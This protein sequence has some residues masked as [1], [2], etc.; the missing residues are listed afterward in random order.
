MK[1]GK[2]LTAFLLAAGMFVSA[3]GSVSVAA[4]DTQTEQTD[5]GYFVSSASYADADGFMHS[6]YEYPSVGGTYA[7][8]RKTLPSRYSSAEQGYVTSVKDQGST[9]TCWAH[10]A[11]AA[12]ESSLILHNGYT[13][14]LNLS[15][16]QLAYAAFHDPA[17]RLGLFDSKIHDNNSNGNSYLNAGNWN[18]NSL[19]CLAGWMGC[20][21]E[22]ANYSQYDS[23]KLF[24][25]Y[26]EK[27]SVYN[28]ES[29]YGLDTAHLQNC[30]RI[31]IAD[32]MDIKEHIMEYGAGDITFSANFYNAETFTYYCYDEQRNG[33][34]HIVALV[35]WD[36]A[37][38]K[39]NC[40]VDGYTPEQD[41]AW[42]I[43]NSWG[44]DEG[45]GGYMW[46]SY[47]DKSIQSFPVNFYSYEDADNYTYNYQYDD[48]P[49]ETLLMEEDG[50]ECITGGGYAA[51]VFTAQGDGETLEAVSFFSSNTNL[52]Y[53][54]DIYTGVAGSASPAAGTWVQTVSGTETYMGYHTVPLDTP[55]ALEKG[56]KFSVVV[57][58]YVK[59]N[60]NAEIAF[61]TDG[62]YNG[63]DE[64]VVQPGESFFSK[65][66]VSW[67]DI[68]MAVNCNFRIKAFTNAD[69]EPVFVQDYYTAYNGESREAVEEDL[70]K[71]V[72]AVE[73]ALYVPMYVYSNESYQEFQEWYWYASDILSN[74]E[75]Y[76]AVE[77]YHVRENLQS[78]YDALE[79]YCIEENIGP[80]YDDLTSIPLYDTISPWQDFLTVYNRA[81]EQSREEGV[82]EMQMWDLI[83]DVC[84]AKADYMREIVF[85]GFQSLLA[86][87]GDVNMDGKV[88]ILDATCLQLYLAGAE[89][90]D[91]YAV[92][93]A[94]VDDSY[95]TD[96]NDVTEIQLY[97]A[98]ENREFTKFLN[99]L[100]GAD[101]NALERESCLRQMR[102]TVREVE[103]SGYFPDMDISVEESYILLSVQYR[104][105]VNTLENS[106]K[107]SAVQICAKA[108]YLQNTLDNMEAKG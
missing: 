62:V 47:E 37:Y 90:L 91:M 94:D 81:V 43:K 18:F 72:S 49:N 8:S 24:A 95:K 74:T 86:D 56:E 17:D 70:D 85:H 96:I 5:S 73:N 19:A 58:L 20:T 41:G 53:T 3:W 102:R 104:D 61:H 78:A 99:Y 42:L 44:T 75:K 15:E 40:T 2:K 63:D 100:G 23:S 14:D 80:Y 36:D 83:Q 67:T 12:S 64:K 66:A 22:S 38:P 30:D 1:T 55:V 50:T 45:D 76:L 79:P 84:Q 88:D 51:N 6:N 27:F 69:A 77:L 65:D 34:D 71:V 7:K 21:E 39:E 46:I 97:I 33:T 101:P 60:P 57:R 29:L 89:S 87:Y 103:N 4:A 105:A 82:T 25:T 13:A 59:E 9:G 108:N 98:S 11:M 106:E 32:S 48:L 31:S 93:N 10:G 54:I 35:G 26:P 16:L 52:D 28:P 68:G 107:Y 92:F